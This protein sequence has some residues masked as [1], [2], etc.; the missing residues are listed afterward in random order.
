MLSGTGAQELAAETLRYSRR[1]PRLS[2]TSA[3]PG[4]LRSWLAAAGVALPSDL[5]GELAGLPTLGC[6]VLD[7]QGRP[8]ALICFHGDRVY[9]LYVAP[10]NLFPDEVLANEV[11]F[12]ERD[13]W[14]VALWAD[15]DFA[16]VLNG[17]GRPAEFGLRRAG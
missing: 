11:A 5:P 12:V 1:G 8:V 9:H 15:R 6:R 4:E 14:G 10:Q 13:G 3:V 7:F 17:A 16:Y 2:H